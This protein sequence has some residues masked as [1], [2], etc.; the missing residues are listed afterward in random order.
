[1]LRVLSQQLIAR[2][3][4]NLHDLN[5]RV[6]EGTVLIFI[7]ANPGIRQS[8]IGTE[9]NIAR[10]NMAPLV[11]KLEKR[12][13]IRKEAIDGRSFGLFLTKDGKVLT[14]KVLNIMQ[15]HE[16]QIED[17]IPQ[18]MKGSFVES[19]ISISKSVHDS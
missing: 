6:S 7:K 10:A 11:G 13:L 16:T 12:G 19:L 17:A 4:A 1:M 8:Q 14:Q 18:D 3:A 15:S 2:L 5:L 9:I